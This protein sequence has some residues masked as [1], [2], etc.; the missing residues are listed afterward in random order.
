[1]TRIYNRRNIEEELEE[2][3]IRLS[4]VEKFVDTFIKKELINKSDLI[5]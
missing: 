3:G 4:T 1:M 5:I 2:D